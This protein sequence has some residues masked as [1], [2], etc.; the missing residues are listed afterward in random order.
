MK[1]S[2]VMTKSNLVTVRASSLVSEAWNKMRE[3]GIHQVPV[4]SGNKYVGML[5]Y[6]EMLR[7]RSIR[8]SSRVEAFMVK[9]PKV[10][11]NE[12]F[13]KAIEM[14][15]DSGMAAIPVIRK[16]GVLV[17][18]FSRSDILKNIDLVGDLGKRPVTDLMSDDPVMVKEMDKV[19]EALE[20][21]RSLDESEI[22]VV[23]DSGKLSGILKISDIDSRALFPAEEKRR[24][25]Y[26]QPQK[27]EIECRSYMSAPISVTKEATIAE[28]SRIL[29]E[30]RLHIVPVVDDDGRPV[31][32]VDVS[33]I[34][35]AVDTGK[36]KSG[37]LVQVSG[38]GPWD[39]D[40][41]DTIF[42]ESGKFISRLQK[43]SG[44]A[45]GTFTIHVTK[46]ENG[47]KVK[48]S[49]RTKLFGGNFNMSVDDYDWNFGKCISRIFETYENRI[50]K[51]KVR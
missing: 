29:L 25:D 5:S 35:N 16:G 23:D 22:P 50:K 43:L 1:V 39:D 13:E 9:T 38:L 4:V 30:N 15:K 32:V 36:E 51:S 14:L 18:I 42:F 33:D 2:E 24:R 20:K 47:G 31:G 10:D 26:G 37:I 6:R 46:Y 34:V 28:C 3:T 8:P 11:E 45:N 44:I 7:R 19:P 27:L 21:M 48:Y 40:L 12:K 49:V 41:Y 17:G